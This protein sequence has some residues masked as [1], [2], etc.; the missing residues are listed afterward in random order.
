[1]RIK[2]STKSGSALVLILIVTAVLSIGLASYV[3]LSAAQNASVMRSQTW[4]SI[5]P[6]CEAGIEEAMAHINDS[7]I[8]T[9]FAINGWTVSNSWFVLER[10]LG[11]G[12]YKVAISTNTM[13]IIMSTAYLKDSATQREL[14]RRIKVTTSRWATGMKGIVARNDLTMTSTTHVDS[15]DSEDERYSTGG[16]YDAAKHKDGGFAGSVNGN[17]TGATVYGSVATGP[18]GTAT[19]NV[20]DFAWVASNTGI[21]PGHVANDLNLAFPVVQAPFNGGAFTDPPGGNLP[22]T[23]YNYWSTMVTTPV[24]PSTTPASPITTNLIGTATVTTYPSGVSPALITTNYSEAPRS[25]TMPAAGTY[26]NLEQ[27]G[28]WYYYEAIS[29]YTYQTVTY[30]YS[31][32]ASNNTATLTHFSQILTQDRYEMNTLNMTGNDKMLVLTDTTLYVTGDFSM[33]GNSQIIIAPGASLKLFVGGST[34]M[35]GN[36]IANYSLDASKF[37]YY[38]LPSNTEISITGN[39]SFTGA[40]YAPHANIQLGGGGSDIYDVVG[41]IVGKNVDMNGH[42][43]FHY[44]ERLGRSKTQSKFTI[45][46]WEENTWSEI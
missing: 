31:M 9:N 23:N 8:G 14:F 21:Q 24:Y 46:S 42:F 2:S 32:T 25:K 11:E 10:E 44:D 33:H 40:I 26:R 12:R 22:L 15:F 6:I 1:M 19:G 18:T 17:V 28:A 29:S 7:A 45:A 4:N 43:E 27:K 35:A 3:R 34:T 16:R 36:G 38:G 39:A 41:A 37:M 20:G 13:P 5:V 30:T